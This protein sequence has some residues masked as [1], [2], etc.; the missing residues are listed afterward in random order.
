MKP[1]FHL[2]SSDYRSQPWKN[3]QGE[4]KEIAIS[5]LNANFPNDKFLWRLSSAT[6]HSV[7]PFSL[8]PGYDRL[9]VVWQGEGLA[10]NG[11]RLPVNR[12]KM[13]AGE[14]PIECAPL[15]P[16]IVDLG[17]IFD[18]AKI[19]AQLKVHTGSRLFRLHHENLFFCARGHFTAND[20]QVAAGETLWTSGAGDLQLQPTPDALYFHFEIR[21]IPDG[22]SAPL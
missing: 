3:G 7:N 16:K 10:L 20:D 12:P 5:P 11:E 9:L 6:I 22:S 17:L 21:T 1:L 2:K 13:F 14:E 19:A 15:G 8:F 4:T 18:R